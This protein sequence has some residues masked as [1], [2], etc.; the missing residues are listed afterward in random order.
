LS[1]RTI[2]RI[3]K[4]GKGSKYTIK[5]IASTL[6]L[7]PRRL[8]KADNWKIIIFSFRDTSRDEQFISNR[9]TLNLDEEIEDIFYTYK[10]FTVDILASYT[11]NSI[12]IAEAF[13]GEIFEVFWHRCKS[14]WSNS[15]ANEKSLFIVKKIIIPQLIDDI[16][17]M[18]NYSD[19]FN[20]KVLELSNNSLGLLKYKIQMIFRDR[21][22]NYIQMKRVLYMSNMYDYYDRENN[23]FYCSKK[24]AELDYV[25]LVTLVKYTH[26]DLLN[27]ID[28]Y[29]NYKYGKMALECKHC[30]HILNNQKDFGLYPSNQDEIFLKLE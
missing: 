30:G 14:F 1:L 10:K 2:Q 16:S 25:D 11:F 3:E 17:S 19:N 4:T 26:D 28:D 9:L 23:S 12:L 7:H 5:Q 27:D 24:C 21:Y 29:G 15:S 13:E 22:V 8:E 20:C 6:N 18:F